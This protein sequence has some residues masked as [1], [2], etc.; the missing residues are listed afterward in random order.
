[1]GSANLNIPQKALFPDLDS[2][3]ITVKRFNSTRGIEVG[4]CR[5]VIGL[6]ANMLVL[7]LTA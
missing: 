4:H 2:H 6:N 1:M 5:G 3:V 7:R